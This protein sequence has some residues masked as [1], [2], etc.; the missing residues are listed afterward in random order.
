MQPST[1]RPVSVLEVHWP[2][3][4][5]VTL[6]LG[7]P[8]IC[9]GAFQLLSCRTIGGRSF[10]E[11]DLD[12]SCRSSE[13]AAWA[14]GVA[15]PSILLAGCGIPGYYF[16]R[17]WRLQPS[18]AEHRAVYGFLFSGYREECWWYE[19]WN[20]VRKALF[21]GMT[22]TLISAGPAMQAW[23]AL[24]L[25]TL[26]VAVFLRSKPYEKS[27]LNE[28]ELQALIVDIATLFFGLALFLNATNAEDAKSDVLAVFLSMAIV[29]INVWFVVRV[30]LCWRQHSEYLRAAM[31]TG[32]RHCRR[33]YAAAVSIRRRARSFGASNQ[34]AIQWSPN[35]TAERGCKVAG[36]VELA[37]RARARV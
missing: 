35:P 7:H 3:T 8:T 11:A 19:L 30:V 17:M 13:Y 34:G 24:L 12:V 4:N 31:E 2:V 26:Y 28:L 10:L 33:L 20:T 32:R 21:T 25:L 14:L 1:S 29:G 18:L 36:D 16:V 27:W 6:I 9:K 22:I 37:L 5:L 15:M 23:G